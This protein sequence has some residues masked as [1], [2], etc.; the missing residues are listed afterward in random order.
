MRNIHLHIRSE[1]G[2]ENVKLFWQWERLECK[3]ADFQNH[4]RFL[5]RCLSADIIPVSIKLKSNIRTPKGCNILKRAER[6]LLN[7]RIRSINNNITMIGIQRDTCK[8]KLNGILDKKTMDECL[9]FIE[10]IRKS[11]CIKILERQT[12]KFNQLCQK[13]T[14]GCLICYHGAHGIHDHKQQQRKETTTP[15]S[16]TTTPTPMLTKSDRQKAKW[17]INISSNP[18]TPAQESLLSHGPNFAVVL[19]GPP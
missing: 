5:L 1:Y 11:R 18:L 10:F 12:I 19:R 9:E 6:A 17:V 13:N 16:E 14:G 7:E 8:N 2:I 4:R 3:I 15:I